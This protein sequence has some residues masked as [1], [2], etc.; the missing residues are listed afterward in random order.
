MKLK[1]CGVNRA[2]KHGE[3]RSSQVGSSKDNLVAQCDHVLT[4]VFTCIIIAGSL[5]VGWR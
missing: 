3:R 1:S 5:G 2:S 4:S